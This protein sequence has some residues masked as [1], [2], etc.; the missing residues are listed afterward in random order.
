VPAVRQ[1]R[2]EH[3]VRAVPQVPAAQ[4]VRLVRAGRQVPAVRQARVAHRA[5]VAP[6]ERPAPVERPVQRGERRNSMHPIER[7]ISITSTDG[8]TPLNFMAVATNT[9]SNAWLFVAR[10]RS[11]SFDTDCSDRSGSLTPGTYTAL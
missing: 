10:T 5:L 11:N 1:A 8:L 9:G 6:P 3:R 4:A 7:Q 2:A